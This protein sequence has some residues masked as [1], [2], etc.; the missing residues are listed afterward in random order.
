MHSI[1]V[2]HR[3]IK[4][5]NVLVSENYSLKL[6]DF[7]FSTSKRARQEGF[8]TLVGTDGYKAPEVNGNTKYDPEKADLFAICVVLFIMYSGHPPF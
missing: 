3:D 8:R 2:Y 4:P 6:S 7:G 1:D 5:E